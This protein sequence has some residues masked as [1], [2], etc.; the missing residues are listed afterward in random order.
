MWHSKFACYSLNLNSQLQLAGFYKNV[1]ATGTSREQLSFAPKLP[2]IC[3]KHT[4]PTMSI[5]ELEYDIGP[6]GKVDVVTVA[7][8][9]HWFDHLTFFK[10]VNWALRR[11][12]GV[13]A[14]WCYTTP[15]VDEFVHTVLN[16]KP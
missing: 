7:Q 1:V 13:L 6:Q 16:G 4:P 2:N 11:P 5:P 12:N 10:H 15:R 8:A 9:L 3:Y 14:V